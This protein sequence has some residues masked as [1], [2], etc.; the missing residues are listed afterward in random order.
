MRILL[1][2]I[3]FYPSPYGTE[4]YVYE[5][6]KELIKIG[7]EVWILTPVVSGAK[8]KEELDGIHIVRFQRLNLQRLERIAYIFQLNKWIL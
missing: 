7:H 1:I 8:L 6:A 2:S 3:I 4:R 5:L